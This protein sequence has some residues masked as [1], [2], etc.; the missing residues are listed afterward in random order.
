MDAVQL[1]HVAHAWYEARRNLFASLRSILRLVS[2]AHV[3]NN[4]EAEEDEEADDDTYLEEV[5]V[6][7]NVPIDVIR[8]MQASEYVPP[9]RSLSREQQTHEEAE[10]ESEHEEAAPN[11]AS[12]ND[13]TSQSK[14]TP[15]GPLLQRLNEFKDENVG[16]RINVLAIN[17]V[18]LNN[19]Y[20]TMLKKQDDGSGDLRSTVRLEKIC[21][22][23]IH[24]VIQTFNHSTN[25]DHAVKTV[26]GLPLHNGGLDDVLN[27]RWFKERERKINRGLSEPH[28]GVLRLTFHFE[29]VYL[30]F[31][32]ISSSEDKRI[33][34]FLNETIPALLTKKLI[35]RSTLIIFPWLPG[36]NRIENLAADL[37]WNTGIARYEDNAITI[38][39]VE[40]LQAEDNPFVVDDTDKQLVIKQLNPKLP[41]LLM[42]VSQGVKA[43]PQPPS[44]RKRTNGPATRAF[45]RARMQSPRAVNQSPRRQRTIPRRSTRKSNAPS[46]L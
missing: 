30:D 43:A 46:S 35:D 27:D 14:P 31:Y 5:L 11:S 13:E 7:A 22:R 19:H 33:Q 24:W 17:M 37:V 41:F 36:I 8:W 25:P 10:G 45:T 15:I 3:D 12:S 18:Q 16:D 6:H 4:A 38:E 23:H 40:A 29:I 26:G 28:Q 2:P 34:T 21:Q 1:H 39:S 42:S 32:G 20:K 44:P 9:S